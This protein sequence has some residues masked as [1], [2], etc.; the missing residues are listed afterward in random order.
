M[1][2]TETPYKKPKIAQSY[3]AKTRLHKRIKRRKAQSY[4]EK[5]RLHKRIIK[6]RKAQSYYYKEHHKGKSY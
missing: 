4:Y 6:R 3:I 2:K 1:T 5:T